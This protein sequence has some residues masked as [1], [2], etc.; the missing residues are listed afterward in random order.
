MIGLA[1]N[2]LPSGSLIGPYK[3]R[4]EIFGSGDSL[5]NWILSIGH[6]VSMVW[7]TSFML[8]G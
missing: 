8:T 2:L 5:I 4:I 6:L 3:C 1:V 7:I